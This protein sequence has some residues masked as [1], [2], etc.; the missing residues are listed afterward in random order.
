MCRAPT[1]FRGSEGTPSRTPVGRGGGGGEGVVISDSPS[2]SQCIND[3]QKRFFIARR[4]RENFEVCDHFCEKNV[5]KY[6]FGTLGNRLG[7]LENAIMVK[8][9]S[10]CSFILG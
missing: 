3:S 9:C 5:T 6:A 7:H 1:F 8:L 4:R 10:L 2:A